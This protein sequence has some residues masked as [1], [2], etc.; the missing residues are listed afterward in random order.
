MMH[1]TG[2]SF[3]FLIVA[4]TLMACAGPA[5]PPL[6]AYQGTSTEEAVLDWSQ[7]GA[8]CVDRIDD[9]HIPFRDH[10]EQ[11]R[12][13]PG[14]HAIHVWSVEPV[15]AMYGRTMVSYVATIKLKMASGHLY[16]LSIDRSYTGS[17]IVDYLQ[18]KDAATERFAFGP[19]PLT[20]VD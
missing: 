6:K 17:G 7:C 4:V 20:P 16:K 10:P 18:I 8:F 15:S 14:S 9:L 5:G 19:A 2:K 1:T 11:A 12:L 13:T 3:G